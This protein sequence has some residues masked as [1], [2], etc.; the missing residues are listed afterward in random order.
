MHLTNLDGGI[1]IF[2]PKQYFISLKE[3]EVIKFRPI[4][5]DFYWNKILYSHYIKDFGRVCCKGQYSQYC[6]ICDLYNKTIRN[7]TTKNEFLF[8]IKQNKKYFYNVLVRGE[9]SKGLQVLILNNLLNNELFNIYKTHFNTI[10]DSFW[11]CQYKHIWNNTFGLLFD[12]YSLKKKYSIF[13]ENYGNDLILEIKTNKYSHFPDHNIYIDRKS[14][15]IGLSNKE[16]Q[17]IK[18]KSLP[19]NKAIEI[20]CKFDEDKFNEAVKILTQKITKYGKS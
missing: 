13:D 8:E 15:S 14:S 11:K 9:E 4:L 1:F 18:N 10:N 6:Y 3:Y 19:L 7:K 20:Y 16:L 2:D 5:L 17:K 12:K